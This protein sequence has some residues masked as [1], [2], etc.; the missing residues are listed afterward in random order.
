MPW[1]IVYW[2]KFL[3][4]ASPLRA[5]RFSAICLPRCTGCRCYDHRPHC[6]V[7][8]VLTGPADRA[9]VSCY[10][11]TDAFTTHDIEEQ[12]ETSYL[13]LCCR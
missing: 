13:E 9:F 11:T 4:K 7:C 8:I 10:S 2:N 1:G 5:S 6:E 12:V 3:D